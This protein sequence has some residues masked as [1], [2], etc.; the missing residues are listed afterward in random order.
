MHMKLRFWLSFVFGLNFSALASAADK[1]VII[2]PHRKSIQNEYVPAFKEWYKNKYKTDVEVE[3]L[4]QGG[5]NDDIKFLRSKFSSNPKTSGI[6]L[7]WGGGTTGHN[8]VAKD[9]ITVK[10]TVPPGIMSQIPKTLGGMPTANSKGTYISQAASSFGIFYNKQLLKIEKLP[11]PITW[12]NL[13]DPKFKGKI[14]LTDPRKSGTISVM[15]HLIIHSLGWDKGIQLLTAMGGNARQFTAS[16]SDPIKSIV[17]GDAAATLAIDFYAIAKIGDL[18]ADKLGFVL[19]DGKTIIEGDPV[20]MLKGAPNR[21]TADRFVEFILSPEG[22]SILVLPKGV[23]GGPKLETLG[24]L[25]VN[26]ETYK[27]TEGKR[28]NPINPFSTKGFMTYDTE[29]ESKVRA[30]FDDML[31]ASMVDTHKELR[32]AWARVIAKG[33]KPADIA[34]LAKQP[35]TEKELEAL[36]PKWGDAVFR[37]ETINK[38]VKFSQE[39][40]STVAK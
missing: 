6:D 21:Q 24:R 40:Y 16:S 18:G 34:A 33:S 26:S 5:T 10:I 3:W 37:N 20:S 7:F 27:L 9:D 1:V 4:D 23:A 28:V 38:W 19:P 17:S 13:G 39:K 22:Q 2:S 14:V 31:G 12:E 36:A 32:D 8:E 29:K 30:V 11:E 15:N 25:A 35:A